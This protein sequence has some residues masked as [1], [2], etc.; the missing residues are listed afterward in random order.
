M[1]NIS[2]KITI[3]WSSILSS[4]KLP[5]A[6]VIPIGNTPSEKRKS[7]KFSIAHSNTQDF[8]NIPLPGF[9]VFEVSKKNWSSSDSSWVIIDPRG[10]LIRITNENIA[11]ILAVSGITEGLIQEKCIWARD[12]ANTTLSLMPVSSANYEKA[13]G[14]T[15]LLEEK[16]SINDVQ[17]GDTVFLQNNLIGTYLGVLSLYGT[18]HDNASSDGLCKTQASMRKQVIIIIQMPKY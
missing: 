12:N 10:F 4:S 18:L 7:E 3:G 17:I 16:V 2:K 1:L 13:V 5:S 11:A 14:N 8:D 9:T 15:I 6:E